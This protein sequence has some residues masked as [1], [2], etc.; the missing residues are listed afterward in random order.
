MS[1]RVIENTRLEIHKRYWRGWNYQEGWGSW[2]PAKPNL[3]YSYEEGNLDPVIKQM[4][5]R[6]NKLLK[7]QDDLGLEYKIEYKVVKVTEIKIIEDV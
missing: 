5:K 6:I 4:Q 3:A 1:Q 7:E 2:F